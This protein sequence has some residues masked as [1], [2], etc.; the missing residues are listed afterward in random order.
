MYSI[1]FFMTV[2]MSS[3][4]TESCRAF[5]P[6][7]CTVM[8]FIR[9]SAL[10]DMKILSPLTAGL[11]VGDAVGA[12]NGWPFAILPDFGLVFGDLAAVGLGVRNSLGVLDVG[13]AVG[14]LGVGDAVGGLDDGLFC[15]LVDGFFS[16]LDTVVPVTSSKIFVILRRLF[17][18]SRTN[19]FG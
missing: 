4:S 3:S 8:L 11:D 5:F 7:L 16:V 12:L 6:A 2:R 15:A 18:E 14:V 9:K 10:I 19:S 1:V 13:D 17:P